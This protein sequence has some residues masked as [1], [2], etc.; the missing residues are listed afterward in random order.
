VRRGEGEGEGE[1]VDRQGLGGRMGIFLSSL[2]KGEV[3]CYEL[4]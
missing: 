2:E 1:S 3:S 4:Q